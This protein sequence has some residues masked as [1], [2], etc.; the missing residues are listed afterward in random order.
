[1]KLFF[2]LIFS[3]CTLIISA[4][5]TEGLNTLSTQD[6]IYYLQ[7]AVNNAD[8]VVE[9]IVT[10]SSFNTETETFHTSYK[11][12]RTFKGE[13][14][15][16]VIATR[17]TKKEV[18]DG[19]VARYGILVRKYQLRPSKARV[20]SSGI[21]FF[22]KN[23][24]ELSYHSSNLAIPYSA[25]CNDQLNKCYYNN[26]FATIETSTNV[27]TIVKSFDSPESLYSFIAEN[28]N[29]TLEAVTVESPFKKK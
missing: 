16:E 22:R 12:T 13:I 26:H 20:G 17:I 27:G 18:M 23:D 8:L 29:S 5:P 24:D 14:S 15:S 10:E 11:I 3:L 2:T 6:A 21:Y 25:E 9:G 19:L 7:S 4:Q 1:M 28:T